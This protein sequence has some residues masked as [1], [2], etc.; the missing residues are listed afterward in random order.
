M[1]L[2]TLGVLLWALVHFFPS[3]MPGARTRL[4]EKLGEGP[5]KGLFALNLVIAIVLMVFGWKSVSVEFWYTPL[6]ADSPRL[7]ALLVLIA[8]VMLGAGNAPTNLKRVLRHPMLTGVIVWSAAHLLA[9][10]ESRSVV[11]FGGLGLWALISI[12]TISRQEGAWQKPAAVPLAKDAVLGVI[13]LVLFGVVAYFHEWLF[14]VA[15]IPG[16]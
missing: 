3:L 9:N 12:F 8:F 5:Y 7:I 15:P 11:L 13:S 1:T 16:I 10:G 6:L 2:L 14:G 4:I